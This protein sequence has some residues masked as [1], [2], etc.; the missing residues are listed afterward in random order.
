[1]ELKNLKEQRMRLRGLIDKILNYGKM[2]K[3]SHTIFALPFALSSVVFSSIFYKV[4]PEKLFWI[5]VAMVSG[6]SSAMGFN[7][8]VDKDIDALNPRTKDRELPSGKISISEAIIFIVISSAVFVFSAYKLNELCFYLS[9]VALAVIFFYSFT[10][11]F[12]WFSHLFLGISLGLAPVGAWLAIAGRFDLPPIILGLAVLTWIS[13]SDI[14]Y[15]CQDYEFDKK[16]GLYSI[17][18]KFGIENALKISSLIHAVTFALF[19]SLKFLLNLGGIYT[20]GLFIIAVFLIYQH[21]IVK[22]NDLSRINFAFNNMNALVSTTYFVFS[23]F[24]VMF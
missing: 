16:F 19:L 21:L 6:R 3:F 24:E 10:K 11:R 18:Q 12:T 2:I 14:I 5:L 15:S 17:P 9:P 1:M 23:A 20:V 8:V 4:T 22:P 13:A 7:R